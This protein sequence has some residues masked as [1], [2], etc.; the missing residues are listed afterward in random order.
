MR[1]GVAS[2]LVLA[3]VAGLAPARAEQV[4]IQAVNPP[5]ASS[6]AFGG[7]LQNSYIPASAFTPSTSDYSYTGQFGLDRRPLVDEFQSWSAPLGL[8]SGAVVEEIRVLV[9]DDDAVEDI[10]FKL[11]FRTQSPDGSPGCDGSFFYGAWTGTS[12]GISGRGIITAAPATPLMIQNLGPL[13]CPTDTYNLHG[14][15]VE[16]TSLSHILYGA[17]VVWRR[18]VSPAPGAA[19]F[20]D[21][22]TDHPF[23]QFVEAL[24]ASGITVGC[25]GG[26]FCPDTALTRGQMAVF[27][28]KALGLHWPR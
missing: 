23:F 8:P 25:G 24:A 17:V 2:C 13:I 1:T 6:G 19:N 14:I 20:N 7:E 15:E 27:L 18:S 4:T 9:A 22:P 16:L 5:A 10:S 3:A 21:V 12:A 11:E 26:N 28:S